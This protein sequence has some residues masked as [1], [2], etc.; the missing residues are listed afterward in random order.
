MTMALRQ[1]GLDPRPALYEPFPGRYSMLEGG[2]TWHR[3]PAAAA[4][5]EA[6]C[7]AVVILDTCAMSQLEPVGEY[8]S[9]APR[10]LVIDHHA[11]TDA[12]G[13]RAE[14]LRVCD[15]SAG[16]AC[17]IVA[18]WA[19]A[20]GVRIDTALATALFVG[21]ATDTG[22]FR[23]SNAD[24]RALR[25]AADLIDVGLEPN[26]L[27]AAIYQQDSP[28]RLRLISR[29]LASLQMHANDRLAVMLLR[30]ADFVAA[31]ADRSVTEDLVN[32]ATRLGCTEATILFTEQ[33]GQVR[34]NFRSKR[35]LDVAALARQ[36]GGGGHARAAGARINGD[37]DAT[38]SRV[39]A[40]AVSALGE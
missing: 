23:F 16:A 34:V 5:L 21:I 30:E 4:A 20:A 19:R 8:V 35:A 14:D 3:W 26:E 7:D 11:T 18:E 25:V 22:W 13:D 10:I 39:I 27:Y 15:P 24:S 1:R 36:Y 2:V 32:E 38:V 6:D 12:I 17:I 31:G 28:A 9:R 33:E 37:W 40:A 29:M